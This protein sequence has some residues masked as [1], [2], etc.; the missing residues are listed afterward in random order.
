MAVVL[1][2]RSHCTRSD[3]EVDLR[4]PFS[5]VQAKTAK[6]LH[7]IP[8]LTWY[9]HAPRIGM[10]PAAQ[11]RFG[12]GVISELKVLFFDATSNRRIP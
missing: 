8:P 6:M 7:I 4:C 2:S 10:V 11:S 12:I 1:N 9:C 5:I 3:T